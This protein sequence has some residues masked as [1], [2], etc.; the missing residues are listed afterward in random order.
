MNLEY[1]RIKISSDSYKMLA[2]IETMHIIKIGQTLRGKKSVQK[3]IYRIHECF[4]STA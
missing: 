3:Q 1:D 4:T 2:R